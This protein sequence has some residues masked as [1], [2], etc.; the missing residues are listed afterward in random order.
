[1]APLF[2]TPGARFYSLQAGPDREDLR[3][4]SVP[5]TDLNDPSACVLDT[6]KQL[7]G[8][9]LVITVDTMVA[10]LAGGMG[11]PVW[12]LL[13]FQCDWRWM[14]ARDDSPWY[15]T[16]RLFRQTRPG[17]WAV[18]MDRV[19]DSLHSLCSG[20]PIRNAGLLETAGSLGSSER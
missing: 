11:I 3:R 10:H 12:T 6:A 18:A 8:F 15:P 1:M 20:W 7:N 16:M 19:V 14:L 13:P 4:L 5:I 2:V 17:D 9:D